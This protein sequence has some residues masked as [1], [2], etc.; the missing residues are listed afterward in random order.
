[1]CSNHTGVV[2]FSSFHPCI[3]PALL[4]ESLSFPKAGLQG[5]LLRG[6]TGRWRDYFSSHLFLSV[7]YRKGS[8]CT[9]IADPPMCSGSRSVRGVIAAGQL[10]LFACPRHC[11]RSLSPLNAWPSEKASIQVLWRAL[12]MLTRNAQS[13]E[14]TQSG[15]KS[16]PLIHVLRL[17]DPNI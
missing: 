12:R 9:R 6:S 15:T 10:T 3:P 2:T 8:T 13:P 1:M 11:Q 17:S 7:P 14:K 5:F 16:R 4:L